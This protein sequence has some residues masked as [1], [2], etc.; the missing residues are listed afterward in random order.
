MTV[1][2]CSTPDVNMSVTFERKGK[3]ENYYKIMKMSR[4]VILLS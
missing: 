3:K 4:Q 2:S 1:T